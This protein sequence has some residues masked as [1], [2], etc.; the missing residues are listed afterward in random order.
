MTR[1]VDKDVE[2]TV[3]KMGHVHH[4]RMDFMAMDVN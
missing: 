1:N 2:V 3:T 4:V